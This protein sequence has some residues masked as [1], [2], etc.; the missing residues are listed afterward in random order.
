[1]TIVVVEAQCGVVRALSC[2]YQD[3]RLDVRAYAILDLVWFYSGV[4]DVRIAPALT[5]SLI[6]SKPSAETCCASYSVSSKWGS[7]K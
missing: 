6:A 7:N 2:K 3:I 4:A 1:M 5:E